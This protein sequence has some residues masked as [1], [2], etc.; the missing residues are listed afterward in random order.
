MTTLAKI[1]SACSTIVIQVKH[2][3]T[4]ERTSR[5]QMQKWIRYKFC[6]ECGGKLDIV[7]DNSSEI[8]NN[9]LCPHC[10]QPLHLVDIDL[11]KITSNSI[12]VSHDIQKCHKE[13]TYRRFV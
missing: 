2:S 11:E 13:I 9:T 5:E 1:C 3:K 7:E 4:V 8:I 10:E 12:T 6:P